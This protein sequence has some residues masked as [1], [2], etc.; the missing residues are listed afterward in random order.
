M[1]QYLRRE[2][3]KKTLVERRNMQNQV[4]DYAKEAEKGIDGGTFFYTLNWDSGRVTTH[5][6]H[7]TLNDV[8][9]G[10]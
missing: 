5:R 1:G 3:K 6:V 2:G 7:S 9:G 8:G 10:T 4:A